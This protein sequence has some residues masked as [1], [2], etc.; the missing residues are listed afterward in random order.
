M[1]IIG[2][3]NFPGDF[4]LFTDHAVVIQEDLLTEEEEINYEYISWKSYDCEDDITSTEGTFHSAAIKLKLKY[5]FHMSVV[6]T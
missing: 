2:N 3:E 1:F 4:V 5:L 6:L